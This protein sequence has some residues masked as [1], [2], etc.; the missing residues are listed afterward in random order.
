MK[1]KNLHI[2]SKNLNAQTAFY[3]EV[4]GFSIVEKST[5]K[6]IFKIGNS[7]L[8]LQENKNF[9]P[10]HIA[11]HISAQKEKQAL[12][13]LKKRVEILKNKEEEIIDFSNWEAKSIY[14]YD[15]DKNIIEFISRK[16]LFP[17]SS[18]KFTSADICGIAEIGLA[19]N[20]V[21]ST[22]K[23]IKNTSN[24]EQYFGDEEKFC[25]IGNDE[26]LL[27]TVDKN[28]KTWFPTKDR[29]RNAAFGLRFIHEN[30]TFQLDYNGSKI[31]LEKLL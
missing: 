26:G 7:T 9:K 5:D 10:Y 31:H 16:Y 24:L 12:K 25:V 13:W 15:E 2:Y 4:L 18:L 30:Q 6:I 22:F 17:T 21:K 1:I 28:K 8:I 3:K 11:F 29:S 23:Y 19:V 20:N 27:I 14:F